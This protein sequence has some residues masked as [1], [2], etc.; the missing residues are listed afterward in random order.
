MI[1]VGS[2]TAVQE[3]V[4]GSVTPAPSAGETGDGAGGVAA[5]ARPPK[6]PHKMIANKNVSDG[7]PDVWNFIRTPRIDQT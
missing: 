2:L 7:R 3:I 5:M 6:L 4:N 1:P